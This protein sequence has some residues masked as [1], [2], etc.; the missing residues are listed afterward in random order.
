[1]W[2]KGEI[3]KGGRVGKQ[4]GTII[5]LTYIQEF[6]TSFKIMF[7]STWVYNNK[8]VQWP[9]KMMKSMMVLLFQ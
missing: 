4:F 3:A 5:C 1:M 2:I 7:A 8:G 6:F 9:Y